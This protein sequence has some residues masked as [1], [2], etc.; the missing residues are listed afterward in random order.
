MK[1][2][3]DDEQ[4]R[5]STVKNGNRVERLVLSGQ[6]VKTMLRPVDLPLDIVRHAKTRD[7]QKNIYTIYANEYTYMDLS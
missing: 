4:M 3:S 7:R 2:F 1:N 5:A 6:A